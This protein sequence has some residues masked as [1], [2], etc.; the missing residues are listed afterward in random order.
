MP[1]PQATTA[2][3]PPTPNGQAGEAFDDVCGNLDYAEFITYDEGAAP[4]LTKAGHGFDLLTIERVS[5]ERGPEIETL[6]A[7]L[8]DTGRPVLLAPPRAPANFANWAA[9]AWNGSPQAARA[10]AAAV[11]LLAKA[12]GCQPAG[13]QP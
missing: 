4:A 12:Q 9:V 7:A 1:G 2:S 10:I 13:R 6:N 8:F 3:L 11:P 5:N